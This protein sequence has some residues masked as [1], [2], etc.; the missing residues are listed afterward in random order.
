MRRKT[1]RKTRGGLRMILIALLFVISAAHECHGA[2]ISEAPAP[3]AHASA[4]SLSGAGLLLR[5]LGN[6]DV[7]H[8]EPA[9]LK[10]LSSPLASG[11]PA[12]VVQALPVDSHSASGGLPRALFLLPPL[13]S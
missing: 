5:W 4:G 11:S 8:A 12:G 3:V 10:R 1:R 6:D 7:I 9:D 2:H 13:S